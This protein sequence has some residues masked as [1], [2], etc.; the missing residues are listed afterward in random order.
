MC[1]I[2]SQ[3]TSFIITLIA[4]PVPAHGARVVFVLQW[5]ESADPSLKWRCFQRPDHRTVQSS[6]QWDVLLIGP[7]SSS[8]SP[9]F[10]PSRANSL[11][12]QPASQ[13]TVFRGFSRE[14]GKHSSRWSQSGHDVTGASL[15]PPWD[16]ISSTGLPPLPSPVER[17]PLPA[18]STSTA[19]EAIFDYF[20]SIFSRSIFVSL[21]L[22]LYLDTARSG[23]RRPRVRNW[24]NPESRSQ[25]TLLIEA[26]EP[27]SSQ[28]DQPR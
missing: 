2:D 25:L 26:S 10:A 14:L 5:P 13:L 16:S 12:E 19:G 18:T 15:A 17:P 28:D 8:N 21:G 11:L 4:G 1:L 24:S 6:V 9:L 20:S 23:F 27:R 22:D 3:L 7:R